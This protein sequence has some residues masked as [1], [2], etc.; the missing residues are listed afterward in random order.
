MLRAERPLKSQLIS[1]IFR[2]IRY[3]FGARFRASPQYQGKIQAY[4]GAKENF[5][6]SLALLLKT[7]L[8][9]VKISIIF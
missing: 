2:K 6:Q 9:S 7:H 3:N 4:S 1:I 8:F 5:I